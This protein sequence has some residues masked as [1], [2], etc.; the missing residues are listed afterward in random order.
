MDVVARCTPAHKVRV[1]Q[2]FQRLR[3]DGGDDRGRRQRR[4]RDP[5]RRRRDR[6][7]AARHPRRPAAADLVVTDDR[8]ETIVSA[9]I[10]GRAMWASVRAA[11]AILI[12]GNFGEVTFSVPTSAL[13][14]TTPLS[15]RQI[16]LVNLL[17]DLAPALAIAVR[18]ADPAP[19]R[20]LTEGPSLPRRRADQGDRARAVITAPPG[21]DGARPPPAGRAKRRRADG[22]ARRAGR[23]PTRPD[24]DHGRSHHRHR[25]QHRGIGCRVGGTHPKPVAQRVLRLHPAGLGRVIA[26]AASIAATALP[27]AAAQLRRLPS[28]PPQI[29]PVVGATTELRAAAQVAVA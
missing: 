24:P 23:H 2:A 19:R 27:V 14:G 16:M 11:L 8:L 5:A 28:T 22:G 26:I 3:T 1:V 29:S 17:T 21:P 15:A 12:G 6:P 7:G 25:H 18:R 4:P 13:T 10:E 20:L 9:L